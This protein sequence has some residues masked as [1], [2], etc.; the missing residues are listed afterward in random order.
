MRSPLRQKADGRVGLLNGTWLVMDGQIG[1]VRLPDNAFDEL[2]LT[3]QNGRFELGQDRGRIAFDREAA[4]AAL[5]VLIV[6]GPNR[7][8]Y[9]PAIV[10]RVGPLLRICFDLAGAQRPATFRAPAGTRYFL[11]TYRRAAARAR[12]LRTRVA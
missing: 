10:E 7:G 5:D 6:A 1:G 12:R 9:V 4:P 2:T 3:L 8:R 11:A